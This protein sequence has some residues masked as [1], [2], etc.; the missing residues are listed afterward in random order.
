MSENSLVES[1]KNI[2]KNLVSTSFILILKKTKLNLN[3][4]KILD[5][6]FHLGLI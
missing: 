6:I 3:N 2:E 4:L 1:K 5:M